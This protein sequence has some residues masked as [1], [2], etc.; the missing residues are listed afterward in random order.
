MSGARGS[1]K[2][3]LWQEVDGHPGAGV[4]SESEGIYLFLVRALEGA[5]GQCTWT[6]DREH[7]IM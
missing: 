6:A 2:G 1:W 3:I 4:E 5:L 7:S